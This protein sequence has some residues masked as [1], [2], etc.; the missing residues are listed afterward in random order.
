[1]YEIFIKRDCPNCPTAR[2]LGV[3]L[4]KRGKEVI[5]W[6]LD[7]ADGLCEATWQEIQ[8]TPT[9]LYT[10]GEGDDRKEMHRWIYPLPSVEELTDKD[11]FNLGNE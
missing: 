6:S 9:I 7:E 2:G 3:E 1:M 11:L 4:A 5:F 8:S 10:A